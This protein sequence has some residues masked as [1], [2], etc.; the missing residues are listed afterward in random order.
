MPGPAPRIVGV[1]ADPDTVRRS[2]VA[3]TARLF[4]RWYTDLGMGR[5]IVVVVVSEGRRFARHWI[6]TAYMARRLAEGE[7][8]WERS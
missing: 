4:S 6:V 8:E 3:V 5:H 1:L 7:V 2:A